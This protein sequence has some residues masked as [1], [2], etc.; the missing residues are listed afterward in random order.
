ML[1]MSALT[2]AKMAARMLPKLMRVECGVA[3]GKKKK[4][5][6]YEKWY[7]EPYKPRGKKPKE[8]TT[9]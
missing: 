1:A 6:A 5:K 7:G 9:T 3:L 2:S 8:D 4:S